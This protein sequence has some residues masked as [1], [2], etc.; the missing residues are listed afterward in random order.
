MISMGTN[1]SALLGMLLGNDKGFPL[2][3]LLIPASSTSPLLDARTHF[4]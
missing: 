3:L 1:V 4:T 2:P